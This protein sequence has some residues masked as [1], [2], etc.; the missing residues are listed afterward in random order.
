[1]SRAQLLRLGLSPAQARRHIDNGRWQTLH[2]G[3]HAT[4]TGPV[5]PS[6]RVWAAVLYAA[7]RSHTECRH[8]AANFSAIRPST[9]A[10][11]IAIS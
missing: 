3:V 1:M 4:F 8:R 7:A 9:P 11:R 5:S 10:G 2:T 6:S